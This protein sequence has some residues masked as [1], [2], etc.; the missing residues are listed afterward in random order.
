M[1]TAAQ[2]K[3]ARVA[4]GWG[5][6]DLAEKA[7]ISPNTVARF[8]N[9]K[10]K[11]EPNLGTL[12][13][14]RQAFEQAGVRFTMTAVCFRQGKRMAD[15]NNIDVR[16]IGEQLQRVLQEL[17]EIRGELAEIKT[18]TS[19]IPEITVA[20]ATLGVQVGDIKESLGIIEHDLSGLKMRVERIERRT[21]IAPQ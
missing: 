21:G 7:G 17:G 13:L 11:F 3:M 2:C 18:Q 19:L 8:E 9:E 20:V 16:F 12:K 4:L 1:I 6:R 14:I 10:N 15:E 5:V